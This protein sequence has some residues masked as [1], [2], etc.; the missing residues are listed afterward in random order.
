MWLEF[1]CVVDVVLKGS[2]PTD[3]RPPRNSGPFPMRRRLPVLVAAVV[4]A[5]AGL[6]V[7]PAPAARADVRDISFPQCGMRLPGASQASAGVL[8][9]NGGK[10][11]TKNPCLVQQLKWAKTI[12]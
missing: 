11:F 4:A 10:V 9:A 12:A 3:G 5:L 6:V 8:G 7:A 2:R 1:A